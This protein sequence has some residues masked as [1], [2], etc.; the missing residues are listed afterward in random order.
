MGFSV[1]VPLGLSPSSLPF[2]VPREKSGCDKSNVSSKLSVG[3]YR[4][5]QTSHLIWH[6]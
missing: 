3:S 5:N 6:L 1:F 4:G 2:S